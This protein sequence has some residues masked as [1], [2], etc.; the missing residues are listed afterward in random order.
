MLH[1]QAEHQSVPDMLEK[2]GTEA[3]V[4]NPFTGNQ[5]LKAVKSFGA[6]GSSTSRMAQ[7]FPAL[8]GEG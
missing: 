2:G 8:A 7:E 3:F 5:K 6:A 4:Y 1:T